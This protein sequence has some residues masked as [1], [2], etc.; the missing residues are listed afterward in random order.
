MVWI[1]RGKTY[2]EIAAILGLKNGSVK[3]NLDAVRHKLN[4]VNVAQ[5]CA[6]AVALGIVTA[7]D[8]TRRE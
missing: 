6:A 7:D 4:C 2:A 1:A 8:L 5:A 3:T